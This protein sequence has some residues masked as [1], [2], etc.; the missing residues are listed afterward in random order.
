MRNQKWFV[1]IA[2]LGAALVLIYLSTMLDKGSYKQIIE[3]RRADKDNFFKNH[4]DSP[5]KKE[6]KADFKKLN[7][8]PIDKN[9]KILADFEQNSKQQL[10]NLAQ[11]DN[12][13]EE[14]VN[15]GIAKFSKNGKDFSLTI[16]KD[17][18]SKLYIPFTDKTSG[19]ET[20]GGGRMIDAKK[21][22]GGKILLDFNLAY[23]PYCEYNENY[24]CPIPP[25]E[26]NLEIKVNAG[27]KKFKPHK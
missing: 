13:I 26:N 6:E 9:W 22:Q 8:F 21:K 18:D 23:N 2:L 27:E 11:T 3:K 14:V 12:G 24:V 5:I 4:P 7:Y 1:I 19:N 25:K 17:K 15:A 20:Y 16:L 10:F